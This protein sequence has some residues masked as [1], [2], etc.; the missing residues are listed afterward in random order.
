M[1]LRC[2]LLSIAS[3]SKAEDVEVR[4]VAVEAMATAAQAEPLAL[5]VEPQLVI[6]VTRT[7]PLFK[8]DLMRIAAIDRCLAEFAFPVNHACPPCWESVKNK[9]GTSQ[10]QLY[11]IPE[12]IIWASA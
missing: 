3:L 10:R 4:S 1:K 9:Q 8:G 2:E 7:E 5:A 11:E 12:R 6:V